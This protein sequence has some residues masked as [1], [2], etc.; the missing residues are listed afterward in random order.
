MKRVRI[1]YWPALKERARA[2]RT[3]STST[4]IKL[5]LR[6]SGRQVRGCDFHRQKPLLRFIVDF[7][8]C[9]LMLAI[10]IDG[11]IH[12]RQEERDAERQRLL[13]RWGIRFLRF[14]AYDVEHHLDDVVKTIE[15]W[16][17]Q[18][19]ERPGILRP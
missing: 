9:E 14:S 8:C 11:L 1:P 16:I 5:W 19:P 17:D 12:E 2:L 13:E 7:Y 4:E 10:E 15:H 18:H 6:L 3:A